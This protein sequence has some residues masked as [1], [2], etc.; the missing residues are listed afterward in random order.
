[1]CK[2]LEIDFADTNIKQRK[3]FNQF[4][5]TNKIYRSNAEGKIVSAL[6][7]E[8]PF[9]QTALKVK[10]THTIVTCKKENLNACIFQHAKAILAQSKYYSLINDKVAKLDKDIETLALKV[11]TKK[12]KTSKVEV[13]KVA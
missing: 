6:E 2:D 8:V 1:M 9:S 4:L 3:L 11:E 12:D 10:D 13:K 7:S 5:A